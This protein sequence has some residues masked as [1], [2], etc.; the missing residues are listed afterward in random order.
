[1]VTGVPMLI[2]MI[3]TAIYKE[4]QIG[5]GQLYESAERGSWL[6]ETA[7]GWLLEAIL[8]AIVDHVLPYIMSKSW[9]FHSL[10]LPEADIEDKGKDNDSPR[11]NVADCSQYDE[12]VLQL[13]YGGAVWRNLV[14][15]HTVLALIAHVGKQ[16]TPPPYSF[17]CISLLLQSLCESG[18]W[19]ALQPFLSFSVYTSIT[20]N[21]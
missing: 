2:T 1:M 7:C 19:D 15:P 18:Y 11:Q 21:Q 16:Q 20:I 12:R 8:L 6:L 5:A 3:P 14:W 13:L 4:V 9:T 10:F 17:P